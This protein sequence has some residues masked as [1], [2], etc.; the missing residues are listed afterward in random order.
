MLVAEHQHRVVNEVLTQLALDRLVQ[1]PRQIEL[2]DFG[3]EQIGQW[4]YL[5]VGPPQSEFSEIV[6]ARPR[7][8]RSA[9]TPLGASVAGFA[10]SMKPGALPP[11]RHQRLTARRGKGLGA[12]SS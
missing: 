4:L 11:L 1:R 7:P 5:H 8:I 10:S 2:G 3:A 9:A 6:S 12:R